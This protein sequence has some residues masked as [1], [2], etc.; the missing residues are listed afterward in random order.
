MA[1]KMPA[2]LLEKFAADREAKKA[3]SGEAVSGS[4]E[5]R[6]RAAAKAR[7]AKESIFRK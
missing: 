1:N 6:K 3:P 2:E 4:A 5:T 7:K